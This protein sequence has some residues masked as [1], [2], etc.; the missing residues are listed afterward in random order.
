[1]RQLRCGLLGKKLGHSY[2]PA[3]H[4]ELG[5]YE[6]RLYEKEEHKLEA[7]LRS[8][9]WDGLNVTIPYK[10]TVLPFLDKVSE[11]ALTAGSVNTLIRRPDGTLFGDNTDVYGFKELV[12]RS[13]IQVQGK[14]V[15]ILGS[16]G[17]CA[18]VLTALNQL[19]ADCTVISRRGADNYETLPR[20]WD[21]QLIVNTTPLGMYPSVGAAAVDLRLF[22]ECR[23]VFDL[24]YNPARTALL[25]QAEELSIPCANGLYMLV[26]QAKQS[27]QLFTGQDIPDSRTEAIFQNLHTSAQNI[28]LIGMPGCGKTTLA[29]QIGRQTGRTVLESDLEI[30]KRTGRTPSQ[31]ILEEGEAAF[32][33]IETAVLCDLGKQ[34]GAVIAT[35]GGC[36]LREENYAALHQNGILVWLR[37]KLD[38]LSVKDRPL[39]Q[40]YGL[41][42]LYAQREAKYR[43][44]ADLSLDIKGDVQ[45]V[46]RQVLEAVRGLAGARGTA[47]KS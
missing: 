31:I 30:T 11:T 4:K 9:D 22:P 2:S 7:F 42:T 18:A 34:S 33:D 17:A 38:A 16:G 46:A 32:R 10:K 21:A 13:G 19:G 40:R 27:A 24:I 5:D 23:G 45:T 14:K 41:E 15:L 1:M 47:A 39:T 6:Y 44:F 25:L 36:I 43:R 26:A 3:I 35:G 28:V 29:E 20:H 8:P 37:R 12:R